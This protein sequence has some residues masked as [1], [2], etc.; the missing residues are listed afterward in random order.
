MVQ[1]PS[2]VAPGTFP[3]FTGIRV[4]DRDYHNPRIFSANV[5]FERELM[6][7]MSAYVDFTVTKGTQLTRFFNI[8]VH[9]D[10]LKQLSG[11]DRLGAG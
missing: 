3:L 9:G 1:A 7:S 10:E 11:R 2:P 8:N 6:P 4:F 5:G